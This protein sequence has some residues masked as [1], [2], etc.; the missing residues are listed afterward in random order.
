[1][2]RYHE[3]KQK[4][5]THLQE[6]GAGTAPAHIPSP[7]FA[8]A[9]RGAKEGDQHQHGAASVQ[10]ERGHRPE[11]RSSKPGDRAPVPA[12]HGRARPLSIFS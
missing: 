3:Q 4:A 2:K 11:A 6:R 8:S 1:M 10:Q 7:L 5:L 12:G 9:E